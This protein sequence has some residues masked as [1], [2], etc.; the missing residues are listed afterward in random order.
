[1]TAADMKEPRDKKDC[2]DILPSSLIRNPTTLFL[3]LGNIIANSIMTD[4][5]NFLEN[6]EK[7][8]KTRS[9]LGLFLVFYPTHE[10]FTILLVMQQFVKDMVEHAYQDSASPVR[11]V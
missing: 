10:N 1:M 7:T 2:L 9:K 11:Q 4:I 3:I 6:Y 8:L 5:N